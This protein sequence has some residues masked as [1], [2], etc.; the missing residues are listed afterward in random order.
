MNNDKTKVGQQ[1]KVI[2]YIG[3]IFSYSKILAESYT[4]INTY[5][6]MQ[7]ILFM[8]YRYVLSKS[9]FLL[10]L[11]M[12]ANRLF[13]IYFKFSRIPMIYDFKCLSV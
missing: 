6:N 5:Y 8:Y 12:V 7:C 10:A 3:T 11:P 2:N 9:T 1:Q 4:S 13:G